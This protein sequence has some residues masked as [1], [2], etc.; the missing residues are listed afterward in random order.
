M[1]AWESTF[2]RDVSADGTS[3][4]VSPYPPLL[5]F[6]DSGAGISKARR[7][8]HV[9][10]YGL[11]QLGKVPED[12]GCDRDLEKKMKMTRMKVLELISGVG[13]A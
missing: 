2:C 4:S 8:G 13:T 1:R 3:I 7:H 9:S 6:Q 5:F 10:R 11:T 12:T